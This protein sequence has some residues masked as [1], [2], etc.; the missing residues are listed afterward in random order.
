[1]RPEAVR[2]QYPWFLISSLLSFGMKYTL[3]P[4][5]AYLRVGI[6]RFGARILP[7]GGKER[8]PVT[9]MGSGWLNNYR[10]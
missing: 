6:S 7:S 2:N 1:V 3:K 5:E 4:L 10:V 8:G 9:S